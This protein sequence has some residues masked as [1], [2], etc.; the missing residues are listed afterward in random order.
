MID[1]DKK[2]AARREAKGEGPELMIGGNTYQLAPELP[3]GVLEA[4]AGLQ[5]EDTAAAAMVDLTKALLGEHYAAILPSLTVDDVNDIVADVMEEY[6]L[7][8]PLPSPAS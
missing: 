8:R 6:G 2:R 7:E 3:F 1:I 5:D 4:M